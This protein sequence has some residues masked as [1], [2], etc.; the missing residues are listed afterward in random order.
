MTTENSLHIKA[1]TPDD[2]AI[3]QQ[4]AYATWPKAYGEILAKHQLNYMLETMYSTFALQKQFEEGHQFYIAQL[5]NKPVG[6]ADFSM[7]KN[8]ATY[9]LH[10]LY[11]LP[12]TQ[13]TGTGKALLEFVIDKVKTLGATSLLLNVNRFNK[14]K[15]FYEKNGFTIVKETDIYI[16]NG[17]FMNDYVMELKL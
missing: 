13:G 6:F 3:I 1:A 10:K 11:V 12:Q 9:K 14:A 15:S 17:Y 4:I 5:N 2:I 8:P 7:Y 16:G